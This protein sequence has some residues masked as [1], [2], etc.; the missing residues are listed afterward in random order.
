L[1]LGRRRT[2]GKRDRCRVDAVVV[3]RHLLVLQ[4]RNDLLLVGADAG[5]DVERLQLV[6]GAF[7]RRK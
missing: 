6:P 7:E 4:P 1:Q 5:T 3:E 2:V